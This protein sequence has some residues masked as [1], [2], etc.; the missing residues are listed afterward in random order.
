MQRYS[1]LKRIKAW[2]NAIGKRVRWRA[3]PLA[4]RPE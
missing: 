3:E 1:T 2:W 4:S